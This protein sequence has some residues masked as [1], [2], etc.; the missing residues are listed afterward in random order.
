M[1]LRALPA[2]NQP[3]CKS[4]RV[5]FSLILSILSPVLISQSICFPGANLFNPRRESLLS[6]LIYNYKNKTIILFAQ[7]FSSEIPYHS[8]QDLQMSKA[9]NPVFLDLFHECGRKI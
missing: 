1:R 7:H 3:I 2:L 4:F 5:W 9:T 6:G 8:R